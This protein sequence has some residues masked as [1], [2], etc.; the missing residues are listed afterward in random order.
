MTSSPSLTR[1][2]ST[3]VNRHTALQQSY[4]F[5][6]TCLVPDKDGHLLPSPKIGLKEI[7]K[8]FLDFRLI[9]VRRRFQYD[10]N[11]LKK[12]IHILEGFQIIFNALDEA[13]RLIRESN[14]KAD[15]AEKLI[16]KFKLDQIRA[17][18]VFSSNSSRI[19]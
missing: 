18:L 17:S 7:L 6:L 4:N 13:I 5:N 8:H 9:T 12:R 3:E 1:V 2:D 15:A 10:L 14:G 16:K 11:Q 19:F